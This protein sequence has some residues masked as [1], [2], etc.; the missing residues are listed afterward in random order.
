[1]KI[2]IKG[3]R[4]IDPANNMD[5][6]MDVLIE[7]GKIAKIAEKIKTKSDKEINAEGK[8]VA[9]GFVDMH[10]HLREPGK[11]EAET[12]ETGVKAAIAGGFTTV[13]AMPNTFPACDSQAHVRFL[14]EK[15]KNIG[16]ANVLPIG[17]IT[18]ERKGE[19]ISEMAEL[20][21]AGCLA[22]SD[23]GDSVRNS[24]LMRNAMEYA[25][26]LDLVVIDHCEDK[27]LVSDGVMREGYMS[28]VL[29]LKP[30]SSES[31]SS[32]IE[33]DIELAERAG[34]RIHIAHVSTVKGIEII[35]AAKKRGVKVTVEVTPHHLALTD[36]ELKKYDTNMK[37]NP[38][39]A[40]EEGV[41][42][43]KEAVKRGVIDVIATDHAPHE[44]HEKEKEFDYA[45]FGMIGLETAFSVVYMALVEEKYLTWTDL[46][47]K[48][49][50]NPCRILKYDRGT[51]SEG[52]VA[53]IT[54]ID[55]EKEWI[56][57]KKDIIS[58]SKNSPFIGKKM[59]GKVTDVIVEGKI[60]KHA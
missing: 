24:F 8:I 10:T 41:K 30:I 58:K 29:G 45:P 12:V 9:P 55:P 7:K 3:G 11:E 39:L 22:V 32:I 54:I 48:L 40:T 51:L 23:D 31:E 56:Y 49:T 34:A 28:T 4:V 5:K 16:L 17:T 57:E 2:L 6:K 19:T 26:M 13:A 52:A 43:L 36:K 38:P 20:K 60:V 18:K 1:M 14:L 27:E 21:E 53:D 33:R 59:K 15:S 47:A 37:V 42:K 50:I 25:S 46:I 44:E 35:E